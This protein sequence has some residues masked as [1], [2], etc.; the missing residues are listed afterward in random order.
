M[1]IHHAYVD[2]TLWLLHVYVDTTSWLC[3]AI[4]NIY[5]I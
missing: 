4:H 5:D 1:L 2:T 3:Q